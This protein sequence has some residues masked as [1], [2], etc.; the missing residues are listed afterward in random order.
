MKLE[1]HAFA[2]ALFE[3]ETKT[4]VGVRGQLRR[5]AELLGCSRQLATAFARKNA[6]EI[7]VVLGK[8]V[9]YRAADYD[10]SGRPIFSSQLGRKGHYSAAHLWV[11]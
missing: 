9:E 10:A 3:V 2:E 8:R 4:R 7:G 1:L 6:R 11:E 5:V